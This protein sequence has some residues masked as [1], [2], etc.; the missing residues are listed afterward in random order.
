[1]KNKLRLT[2]SEIKEVLLEYLASRSSDLKP[3]DISDDWNYEH[4]LLEKQLLTLDGTPDEELV[5]MI[6]NEYF[7]RTL[8]DTRQLDD[9][10]Y[11][12]QDLCHNWAKRSFSLIQ[13]ILAVRE[14]VK[15]EQAKKEERERILTMF[16]CLKL[17]PNDDS[18]YR[19]LANDVLA[20]IRTGKKSAQRAEE[21]W[22]SLR[23][24]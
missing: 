6:A 1:M 17:A 2:D 7:H 10:N 21:N 5:G 8:S 16:D 19:I 11:E 22:Q 4:M 14:Q 12:V 23:G 3:E 9:Q 24:Q 13:P 20:E 15:I 18:Y